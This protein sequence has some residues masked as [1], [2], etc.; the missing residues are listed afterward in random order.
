MCVNDMAIPLHA[1]I[2]PSLRQ[3]YYNSLIFS[4]S[5]FHESIQNPPA[6]VFLPFPGKLVSATNNLLKELLINCCQNYIV[7]FLTR[8]PEKKRSKLLCIFWFSWGIQI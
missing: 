1:F 8:H 7:V 6:R 3:F 5:Y 4:I 2:P